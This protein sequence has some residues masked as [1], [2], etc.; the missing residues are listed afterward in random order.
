MSSS[1]NKSILVVDDDPMTLRL[2]N[3]HL[4]GLGYDIL[5]ARSGEEAIDRLSG[6]PPT[7]VITDWCMP[8]ISGIGLCRHL[9]RTEG[10]EEIY[11]IALALEQD[12]ERAIAALETG[13][14]DYLTK[15]FNKRELIA[16]VR[17][18]ARIVELERSLARTNDMIRRTNE[19]LAE[20]NTALNR[21]AS[22]DDLTG[23]SNRRAAM[24][25]A[26]T[27]WRAAVADGRS[28]A[29]LRLDV[30]ELKSI[31]E[32]HGHDTGD[33]VLRAIARTLRENSRG[34][35]EVFRLGGEEF[36]ILCPRA[37]AAMATRA[38]ERMRAAVER[39]EFA[40]GDATLALT[41]SIGVAERSP[42][43]R[44]EDHLLRAANEALCDA[45]EAGRNCVRVAPTAPHAISRPR[46]EGESRASA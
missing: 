6:S 16:R 27:Q 22:I 35:E 36:L 39:L 32:T 13:A 12:R 44:S 33:R 18:G 14:D 26:E 41:A 31:N 24:S 3:H 25:A 29:C 20:A 15:P 21:M 1:G 5:T 17:A 2:L 46:A 4:A 11:T 10:L 40:S 28:M 38:A 19:A 8:G 7:M 43:M 23:L 42:D 37:T 45:K 9:R 34:T 30:D